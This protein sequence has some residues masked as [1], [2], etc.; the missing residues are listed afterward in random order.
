MKSKFTKETAE[1]LKEK[2]LSK[3]N[4]TFDDLVAITNW[5]SVWLRVGQK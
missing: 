2:M 4:Y 3:K 5:C 1:T